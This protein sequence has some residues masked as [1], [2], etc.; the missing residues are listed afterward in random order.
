MGLAADE[1]AFVSTVAAEIDRLVVR[2]HERAA[3]YRDKPPSVTKMT[4]FPQLLDFAAI[5][6]LE[7]PI[8]RADIARIVPYT[9]SALVDG[10]VDNNVAEGVVSERE[11]ELELTDGGRAAAEGIVAVQ[12]AAFTDIWSSASD[13]LDGVDRLLASV[14][15][16]GRSIG[17]PRTPSNFAL[18]SAVC[19][20]PTKPGRVLRLITAV[21]YWRADAHGRALIE[22]DLRP[23]E[24]HA[25]NR[26]WDAHRG[27]ERVGQ[28]FEKPGR[29]GVASLEVRGLAESGTITGDGI[30]LREQVERATDEFT[31][32]I[33][34][35]IDEPSRQELAAA[36]RA[37]PT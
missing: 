35:V 5:V 21:R 6:L 1:R 30:K 33:Y 26:L 15:R 22:A 34:D 24:A 12:E 4:A 29:K 3:E 18:F 19:D 8:T 11:G 16:H 32:P 14:V 17:P 23:F 10:L 13:E 25:L 31:A 2:G 9:P 28:G 27:L 20:R 37:L 36:L 7:Q